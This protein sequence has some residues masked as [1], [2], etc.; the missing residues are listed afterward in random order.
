MPSANNVDITILFRGLSFPVGNIAKLIVKPKNQLPKN[1]A[2][3][4]IV[5]PF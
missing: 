5:P 3:L 4:C 2:I 1:I